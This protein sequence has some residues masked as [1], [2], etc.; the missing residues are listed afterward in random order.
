MRQDRYVE[1]PATEFVRQ[2]SRP[3]DC[4]VADNP[5]FLHYS[6]R[7]PPPQLAETSQTRIDTGFLNVHSLTEV[8]QTYN[9]HVVATVTPRFR[10]SIPGLQDW[11]R[12]R[13]VGE[14]EK[15]DF[16]VFFGQ[17]NQPHDYPIPYR[18]GVWAYT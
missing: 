7:L 14:Y 2:I 16:F 15:N 1:H 12:E 9:C 18:G 10:E 4:V 5:V 8:L 3:E 11:L 17:K 6:G 13:Y